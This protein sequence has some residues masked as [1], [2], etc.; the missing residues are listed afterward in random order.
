TRIHLARVPRSPVRLNY[1]CQIIHCMERH[2]EG[3]LLPRSNQQFQRHSTG[4]AG[5][6]ATDALSLSTLDMDAKC[7]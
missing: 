7:L 2:Y 1:G 4:D 6:E 3:D 5:Q